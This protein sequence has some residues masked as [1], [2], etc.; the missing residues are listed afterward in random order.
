MFVRGN[1]NDDLY[2]LNNFG[3][4]G[5]KRQIAE[6]ERDNRERGRNYSNGNQELKEGKLPLIKLESLQELRYIHF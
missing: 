6:K 4:R 1:S 3:K 2:I 5:E